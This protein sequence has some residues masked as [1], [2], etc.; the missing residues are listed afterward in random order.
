MEAQGKYLQSILEKACKLLDDQSVVAAGLEASREEITKQAIKVSEDSQG[1]LTSVPPAMNNKSVPV[2]PARLGD[3]TTD[4]ILMSN[5]SSNSL[6]GME[7]Q[8]AAAALKKRARPL[9]STGDSAPL[10]N[11]NRQVEWTMPN[12]G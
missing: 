7:T 4:S 3:C 1:M 6:S 2:I 10:D 9:F 8:A 5:G 12:I 11:S